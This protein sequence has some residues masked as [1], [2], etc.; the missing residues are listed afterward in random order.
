M[1]LSKININWKIE[2]IDILKRIGII[3]SGFTGQII[4]NLN[5]GGITD[6]E[7]KERISK[8]LIKFI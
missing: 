1:D 5:E 8:T 2:L 7:R 3:H 4:L 6:L